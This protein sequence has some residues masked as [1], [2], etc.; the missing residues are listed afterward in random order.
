MSIAVSLPFS[1]L[2]EVPFMTIEKLLLF[3]SKKDRKKAL[4]HMDD[5]L[6]TTDG[7]LTEASSDL[8]S[9]LRLHSHSSQE[10]SPLR[11]SPFKVGIND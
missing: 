6:D 4:P 1:M 11:I 8:S 5:E 3:P 2:C 7:G 9:P 10:G